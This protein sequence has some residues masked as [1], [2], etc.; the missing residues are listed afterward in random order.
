MIVV[1]DTSP[2]NY[3]LL[4]GYIEVLPQLYGGVLI[5]QAISD[6]MQS[7]GAPDAVRAWAA[8][9]PEWVE[10]RRITPV[11]L[12]VELDAGEQEVLSLALEMEADVVLLDERMGRRAAEVKGL[13]VIGTLGILEVAAKRDLIDLKDAVKRLRQTNFR[14]AP[15]LWKRL[16]G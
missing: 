10:V 5:P 13:A 8:S 9:L 14:A 16:G 12:G 11:D 7:T 1:S 2:L 6:E 3:L 4:I 15:A